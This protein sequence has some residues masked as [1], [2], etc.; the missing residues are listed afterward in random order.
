MI[1]VGWQDFVYVTAFD[2]VLWA[3]EAGGALRWYRYQAGH[4]GSSADWDSNSG[5]IVGSGWNGGTYG[6]QPVLSAGEGRMYMVDKNGY[7]RRNRHMDSRSAGS[8]RRRRDHRERVEV[9]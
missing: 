8:R 4:K 7:L 6:Y 5:T 2:G 1:G 9:T 3:A